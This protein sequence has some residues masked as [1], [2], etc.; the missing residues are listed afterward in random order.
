MVRSAASALLLQACG[1]RAVSRGPQE[2]LCFRAA[3]G[4][5]RSMDDPRSERWRAEQHGTDFAFSE[6]HEQHEHNSGFG[7]HDLLWLC[8]IISLATCCGC[9]P[10]GPCA[11]TR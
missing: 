9:S 1:T 10:A 2:Q 11:A 8:P 3:C 4:G 7:H 5:G 6:Q